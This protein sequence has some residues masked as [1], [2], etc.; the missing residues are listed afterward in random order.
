MVIAIKLLPILFDF[1]STYFVYRIVRLKY[2]TG[3]KPYWAA[4]LFFVLPTIFIN[5]AHWGQ[6]DALYTT[7]LIISLYFFLKEKPLLGM[8]AFA[9]SFRSNFKPS[10]CALFSCSFAQEKS[11]LVAIPFDSSGVRDYLH[12][13]SSFREQLAGR[14]HDLSAANDIFLPAFRQFAQL[15]YFRALGGC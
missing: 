14:A 11:S 8:L 10:F 4:G 1:I 7:F 9:L 3:N 5:S 13:G 6:M 2:P 12:T 15:V